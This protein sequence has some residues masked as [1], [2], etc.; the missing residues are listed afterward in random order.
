LA[1]QHTVTEERTFSVE[2]PPD[3]IVKYEVTVNEVS[4]Q[5]YVTVL[6][7]NGF[8]EDKVQVPFSLRDR[9][10]IDARPVTAT[11]DNVEG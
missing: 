2:L 5:G 4:I 7:T 9:I 3:T 8:Y 1:E 11:C 6:R 10:R